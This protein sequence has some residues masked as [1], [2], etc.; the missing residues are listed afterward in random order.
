MRGKTLITV[1]NLK[2][3]NLRGIKSFAMV[4]C[5]SSKDGKAGGIEFVDPPA[6]SLPGDR[7]FFE[8]F[9][10]QIPVDQLNPKRKI[11]ETVQPGFTTLDTKEAAWVSEDKKVHRIM[12]AKGVC[13]TPTLVGASLS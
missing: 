7:I 1:C 2:P 12:S 6:G 9:E 3:A 10:D 5:A 8:G 4:L 13:T 11:F